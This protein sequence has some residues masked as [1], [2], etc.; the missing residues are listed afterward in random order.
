MNAKRWRRSRPRIR[1]TCRSSGEQELLVEVSG[2]YA[3]TGDVTT[4]SRA[5]AASLG[6][7]AADAAKLVAS[8]FIDV[9][10]GSTAV[11]TSNSLFGYRR[12]HRC[13]FDPDDP[14]V[15]TALRPD[16]PATKVPTGPPSNRSAVAQ[17]AFASARSGVERPRSSL[18]NMKS[19]L[20]P[21]AVGMLML[22]MMNVFD[23]RQAEEGRSFFV[24]ARRRH[25]SRR[26][27]FRRAGHDHQ[28]SR[29]RKTPK[30]RRSP[31]PVSRCQRDV[32][33]EKGVLKTLSYSRFWAD[34]K[35]VR[36]EAERRRTSSCRG[37]T[38]SVD[39]MIK[40]SQARRADHALLVYPRPESAHR[41]VHRP[42]A[43]R[44]V[45]HRERKDQRGRSRTSALISRF[46]RCW[47]MCKCWAGL[48]ASAPARTVRSVRR[49]LCPRSRS[50]T[51]FIQRQRR[52]LVQNA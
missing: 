49:S 40:V 15:R 31:A 38:A 3:S 52:D 1:N 28:R 37:G 32:W 9:N 23:A 48:R 20:E 41:L 33:V 6:V 46:R 4:E 30:P 13:C 2:Y 35:G 26:K 27:T 42:H 12:R 21:T 25:T 45:P 51:S 24:E 39:D 8:G 43:R 18:E 19:I 14:H 47:R 44:H 22:R 17:D 10:A 29:W 50:R 11:A 36:A 34:E 16:G 5:R 7:K